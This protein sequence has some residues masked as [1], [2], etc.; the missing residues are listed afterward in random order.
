MLTALSN[1]TKMYSEMAKSK[2]KVETP[3]GEKRVLLHSCCAPCSSAIVECMLSNGIEPVIFYF[4][5]NIF[6]RE[7]YELRK[8]E[9]KRYADELGLEFIDADYGH[10][11]WLACVSG[12]ENE[13][14]RGK[15]CA[16]CF[17][18]RLLKAAEK[19]KE[20]GIGL[21]CTTL[22]SSRWKS[23]DQI[24][25]AGRLA[26]SKFIGVEFWEQ[27]WRK[28]GLSERRNEIIKERNFYNQLYCG[29]EFSMRKRI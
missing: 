3:N 15:R 14:E 22:A 27:D 28:G 11:G 25:A 8:S 9:N 2:L 1:H 21:F 5:P 26:A 4:N 10:D 12:L 23:K 18:I 17:E 29:C 13:P 20:S 16:R 6:P 19:A 24:F 7:E